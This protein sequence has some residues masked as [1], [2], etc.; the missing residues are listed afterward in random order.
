[1]A[2]S[3]WPI[4]HRLSNLGGL[5]SELNGAIAAD[6]KAKAAVLRTELETTAISIERSLENWVQPEPVVDENGDERAPALQGILDNAHAYRH[7]AVV[8]L[9]R[10]IYEASRENETV[11]H[12]THHSLVYCMG[13]VNSSGPMG[14]LLW[15]LFVAAC[16]AKTGED[17]A[18]AREAFERIEKHQGMTNIERAW[19]IVQ[20]V[21]RRADVA[22]IEAGGV[23][24]TNTHPDLWREVSRD[25]GLTIVFG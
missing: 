14:A 12:H 10:S 20:E 1:M 4:I 8:H 9:Y 18:M 22:E 11:Q 2:T 24:A 16:E 17:R 15:P 19:L 5:K 25:M 23:A 13:T 7:S 3:L 6:E 21:W